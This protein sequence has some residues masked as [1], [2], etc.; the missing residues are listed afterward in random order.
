MF[1]TF[2]KVKEFIYSNIHNLTIKMASLSKN[3]IESYDNQIIEEKKLKKI[4]KVDFSK[5]SSI[6]LSITSSGYII[7]NSKI[8]SSG[9]IHSMRLSQLL[10][11]SFFHGNYFKIKASLK[12]SSN[13]LEQEIIDIKL[14]EIIKQSQ[15]QKRPT[16]AITGKRIFQ[17]QSKRIVLQF[18]P[19]SEIQS[20]LLKWIFKIGSLGYDLGKLESFL[21]YQ[22]KYLTLQTKVEFIRRFYQFLKNK[23]SIK[24]LITIPSTKDDDYSIEFYDYPWLSFAFSVSE[25]KSRYVSIPKIMNEFL[26]EKN[27]YQAIIRDEQLGIVKIRRNK[28]Q[29]AFNAP[30]KIATGNKI[31]LLTS[32]STNTLFQNFVQFIQQG[33]DYR[34]FLAFISYRKILENDK[35]LRENN[36]NI[37]SQIFSDIFNSKT[38]IPFRECY[39]KSNPHANQAIHYLLQQLFNSVQ[40]QNTSEEAF[41]FFPEALIINH[42]GSSQ[43]TVDWLLIH[44]RR[45]S[46]IRTH[47]IELKSSNSNEQTRFL[48]SAIAEYAVLQSKFPSLHS[49]F[50]IVSWLLNKDKWDSYAQKFLIKLLDLSDIYRAITK[51]Q[52]NSLFPLEDACILP[53]T[54]LTPAEIINQWLASGVIKKCELDSYVF[55]TAIQTQ[56]LLNLLDYL[57]ITA[58]DASSELYRK[59]YLTLSSPTKLSLLHSSLQQSTKLILQ[60]E[61]AHCTT[62]LKQLNQ[63]PSVLYNDPEKHSHSKVC[64]R[65]RDTTNITSLLRIKYDLQKLISCELYWRDHFRP[66]CIKMLF[67]ENNQGFEFEEFVAQYF[68]RNNYVTIQHVSVMIGN[69]PREIDLIAFGQNADL[70][71]ERLIVSC[72][73]NSQYE[74]QFGYAKDTILFRLHEVEQLKRICSF[75]KGYLFVR[76]ATK[77]QQLVVE[78]WTKESEEITVV[79]VIKDEIVNSEEIFRECHREVSFESIYIVKRFFGAFVLIIYR[80]ITIRIEKT[81]KKE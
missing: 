16:I 18:K 60:E 31:Y 34:T 7:I 4:S 5:G 35:N 51:Q 13:E 20:Q 64:D 6:T 57:A 70:T 37:I 30:T 56:H 79:T 76:V 33:G 36:S 45:D 80:K 12:N 24:P 43:K 75:T 52:V 77:A 66:V 3:R 38:I 27:L 39:A 42:S 15:G 50:I 23:S 9:T 78:D 29:M 61:L 8:S 58:N 49:C 32:H 63:L 26:S 1:L 22:S 10:N 25:S 67:D 54:A 19:T 69:Y 53:Q 14:R 65:R 47:A 40:K 81:E 28:K 48:Q 68:S 72:S 74:S 59:K 17:A 55:Q 21:D 41:F 71:I 11:L 73:D 62:R 44:Y 2:T 46:F